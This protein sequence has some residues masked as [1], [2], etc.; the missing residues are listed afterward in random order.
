[1]Q[2]PN[3]IELQLKDYLRI[4]S[5][6][7]LILI[8]V[9]AA[10]VVA[11]VGFTSLQT[12]YY[13]ASAEIFIELE[14]ASDAVTGTAARRVDQKRSLENEIGFLESRLVSDEVA[15]R[16]GWQPAV[17]TIASAD[18]DFLTVVAVEMEPES[19]MLVANTYAETYLELR[20]RSALD[21]LVATSE[22][23][24]SQVEELDDRIRSI[25]DSMNAELDALEVAFARDLENPDQD[26]A[27]PSTA[28][29][30]NQRRDVERRYE[31]LRQPLTS[32]RLLFVQYLT[33]AQLNSD[34]TSGSVG[35]IMSPARLPEGPSTPRP[36]RNVALGVALG[37]VAG[38]ALAV[39]RHTMTDT[40]DEGLGRAGYVEGLRVVGSIPTF[41]RRLKNKIVSVVEPASVGAEAYRSLRTAVVFAATTGGRRVIQVTSASP[42]EGKSET[43][44]NLSVSLAQAGRRVVLID[45]DLRRPTLDQRLG[46]ANDL[47]GLSSVLSTS[48]EVAE[49]LVEVDG[50]PSMSFLPAGPM[51]ADPAA[52]LASD[53]LAD[54][55]EQLRQH[56]EFVI[57]DSP[58][59]GVV[60]DPLT[61]SSH[62]DGVIV[63]AR[64]ERTRRRD[65]AGAV[66]ALR[67]VEADLFGLVL[68][69]VKGGRSYRDRYNYYGDRSRMAAAV[70]TTS[71][72]SGEDIE[73]KAERRLP[74][75]VGSRRR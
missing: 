13:T 5:R 58:P 26:G 16:L 66:T 27:V 17:E 11:A 53:R 71:N 69:G 6:Q 7:R 73:V 48:R 42:S 2:T 68:N 43:S 62:A 34:L 3:V 72:D 47:P 22:V 46:K 30:L 61:L 21:D 20:R 29:L 41:G 14:P 18:R 4:L 33:T 60:S 28:E 52:L 12:R 57:I 63:V 45:A 25:D 37:L 44:T 38:T 15:R 55:V 23:V 10:A 64:A 9:L 36:V 1:M 39:L 67:Q 24:Q 50:V 35:R 32:Q 49:C 75:L 31:E 40:V 70:D 51:P 19:A 56:F 59:V 54:L 8:L 65:L 74:S